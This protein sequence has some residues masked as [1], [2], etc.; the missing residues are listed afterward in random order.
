MPRGRTCL[1]IRIGKHAGQRGKSR[2]PTSPSAGL[3]QKC[4]QSAESD[5]TGCAAAGNVTRR[6]RTRRYRSRRSERRSALRTMNR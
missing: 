3:F 4:Q 5:E 1:G 6:L 2:T